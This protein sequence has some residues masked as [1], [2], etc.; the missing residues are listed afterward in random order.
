MSQSDIDVL[1]QQS[2][3]FTFHLDNELFAMPIGV[4]RE[5]LEL[6]PITRIPRCPDYMRGVINLRGNAV[7]VVDMRLKFGMKAVTPSV[8]TSIIV[9]EATLEG[10]KTLMGA[11]VD[12]VSEVVEMPADTIDEPPAMGTAIKSE[13]ITGISSIESQFVI[14][15]DIERIFSM[16][17]LTAA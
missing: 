13:F 1:D 12:A 11:L 3:F 2:Q 8:D 6:P 14:I 16:D 4:I 15:V 17:E 10:E 5:V 7:P 9:F